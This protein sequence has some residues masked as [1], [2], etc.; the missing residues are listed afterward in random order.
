MRVSEIVGY[1][2][3][4]AR[5]E[6]GLTQAELA[7][8]LEAFVGRRWFPQTV[9][10]AEQGGRDFTAEELY[11]IAFALQRP[12]ESFFRP[13]P[14]VETVELSGRTLNVR[15]RARRS[16]ADEVRDARAALWRVVKELEGTAA[17]GG[18]TLATGKEEE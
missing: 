6:I 3:R 1:R 12:V 8:H 14:D 2:L 13:P 17:G 9:S 15:P 10:S 16:L 11:G 7:E 4:E 5:Q 18:R